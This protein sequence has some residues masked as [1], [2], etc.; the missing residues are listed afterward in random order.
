MT[1]DLRIGP[2]PE[3]PDQS[4]DGRVPIVTGSGQRIGQ[5]LSELGR[6]EAL[7]NNAAIRTALERRPSQD[8]SDVWDGAQEYLRALVESRR[9]GLDFRRPRQGGLQRPGASE[10]IRH[11]AG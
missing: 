3:M 11:A 9:H 5:T 8:I 7:I 2:I 1:D 4:V 6:V 10:Q